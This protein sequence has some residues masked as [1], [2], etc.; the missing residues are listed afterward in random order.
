MVESPHAVAGDGARPYLQDSSQQALMH[1]DGLCCT[2]GERTLF[3]D[4]DIALAPGAALHVAGANGAGKT[5]LLRILCALAVPDAGVVRW[6]GADVRR[7]RAAFNADLLYIAHAEGVKHDLLAWENLVFQARLHGQALARD[8][9]CAALGLVG[10]GE[11]AHLPA[12]LLSQGQRKRV[13]LAQLHLAPTRQ[14][15]ILDEPFAALDGDAVAALLAALEVHR[16]RGGIVIY[17]THQAVALDGA[18]LVLG[19]GKLASC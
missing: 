5:S 1:A 8:A 19:H 2:R 10:L 17:T 3:A 4:L 9:A 16:A 18:V 6:N 13:A 12:R 7:E 15:W 11:E 14:L